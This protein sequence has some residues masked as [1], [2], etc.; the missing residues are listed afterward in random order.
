MLHRDTEELTKTSKVLLY[1]LAANDIAARA[2][3]YPTLRK[4]LYPEYEKYK[5]DRRLEAMLYRL[6]KQWWIRS[7]YRESKRVIALTQKGRLEALFKSTVLKKSTKSWDGKW[8]MVLFDIPEGARNVRAVL[9]KYLKAFGFKALQESVY[10]YPYALHAQ[11]LTVLQ[12]SGLIRYIRFARVDK[13]D[14]DADLQK[15]FKNLI[16]KRDGRHKEG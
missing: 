7:E 6:H 15:Q 14:A 9:R 3:A 2:F 12:K 11:A 13:F 5:A 4:A 16:P 1:L 10:V 8:R